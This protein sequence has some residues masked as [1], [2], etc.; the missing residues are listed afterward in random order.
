MLKDQDTSFVV[1]AAVVEDSSSSS[2]SMIADVEA[3]EFDKGCGN[4]VLV[5]GSVNKC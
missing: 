3:G 4:A 1:A 2:S 5:I